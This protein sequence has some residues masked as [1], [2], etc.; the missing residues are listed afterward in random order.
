MRALVFGQVDQ[1]GGFAYAANGCFLD[2]FALTDKG[3]DR[4]V[5]VAIHFPVQQVDSFHSH[6]LDDGI[7]PR[8]IATFGKVRNAFHQASHQG[9]EYKGT[10]AGRNHPE[11]SRELVRRFSFSVHFQ[12]AFAAHSGTT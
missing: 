7:Y 10:L 3:D 9:E 1:L 6:G 12:R 5:V 2:R 4:A 11:G 8:F